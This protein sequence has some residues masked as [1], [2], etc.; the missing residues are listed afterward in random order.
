MLVALWLVPLLR[1]NSKGKPDRINNLFCVFL[2][3]NTFIISVGTAAF[4][5]FV[6]SQTPQKTVLVCLLK[7][8]FQL[9]V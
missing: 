4:P 5:Y 7:D 9:P 3:D 1:S 8:N 6:K 2:P